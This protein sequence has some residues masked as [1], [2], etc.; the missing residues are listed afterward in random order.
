LEEYNEAIKDTTYK[1]EIQLQRIEERL[2][3]MAS[4]GS[5]ISD[6]D[7]DLEDEK[8]VTE[9]C[10]RLCEEASARIKVLQ[11][12]QPVL[13]DGK[14]Q[15]SQF[16]RTQFQAQLETNRTMTQNRQNFAM[17]I[18]RLSGRL[19]SIL[20]NDGPDRDSE[21]LR[22]QDE[23]KLAKECLELC[24]LASNQANQTIH[25][26]GEVLADED[27]DQVVLNTIA[28]FFEIGKVTAKGNARQMVGSMKDETARQLSS[29]RYGSNTD[30]R[31]PELLRPQGLVAPSA[32]TSENWKDKGPALSQTKEDQQSDGSDSRSDKPSPNEVRKRKS[33]A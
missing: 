5:S 3:N 26:Y 15:N 28:D 31:T 23:L 20:L 24:N 33:G 9:L 6:S 21:R 1:L 11:E 17:T 7:I 13:Q 29:D 12:E 19:Q 8:A 18:S 2:G 10:I 22:L 16:M 30:N 32:S 4:E 25:I 27:S 14:K